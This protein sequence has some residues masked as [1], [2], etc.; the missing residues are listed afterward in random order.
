VLDA[1]RTQ[2]EA[3]DQLARGRTETVSAYV[4][5]YRAL[6]GTWPLTGAEPAVR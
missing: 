1:E 4:D 2:L 6:G 5:L 3:Q